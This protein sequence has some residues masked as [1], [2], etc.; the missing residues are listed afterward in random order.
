MFFLH[1]PP[2]LSLQLRNMNLRLAQERSTLRT[3]LEATEAAMKQLRETKEA[4]KRAARSQKR[5]A[6]RAEQA[7]ANALNRL[8]SK[9]ATTSQSQACE[10]EI[11]SCFV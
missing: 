11:R 10:R 5:R 3:K 7:L 1:P 2:S 4:I 8:A 6:E 9:E